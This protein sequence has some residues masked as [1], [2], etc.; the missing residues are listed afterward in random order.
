M[1]IPF[2][3]TTAFF[4]VFVLMDA[5]LRLRGFQN[6]YYAIH[7]LHNALIVTVTAPDVWATMTDFKYLERYEVNW[8][9][10]TLCFA[11]H[12]YHIWVYRASL[13]FDDWL[14]HGLMIGLALPLGLTVPR[15]TFLG[16]SLFFTTGLPGGID[17]ALLFCV[18]NGWIARLIEKRINK[19]L[20]VWIRSPGCVAHAVLSI[21]FLCSHAESGYAF[22]T[23]ITAALVGWN[24]QY[25]MQQV[26]ADYAVLSSRDGVH[27]RPIV[28]Q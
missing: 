6:P 18:R 15:S 12:L 7:A 23:L 14:H 3:L 9:A 1:F 17:Y 24:G 25:F 4:Q 20:N 27:G 8:L 26:V 10:A 11:L 22:Q 16:F 2:L 28:L 19:E 13:R 5:A 21:L